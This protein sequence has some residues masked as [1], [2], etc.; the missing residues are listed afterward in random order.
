MAVRW[1]SARW[2]LWSQPVDHYHVHFQG[3]LYRATITWHKTE[4]CDHHGHVTVSWHKKKHYELVGGRTAYRRNPEHQKKVVTPEEEQ[5]RE[6]RRRECGRSRPY[7]RGPGRWFKKQTTRVNRRHAKHC[8]I[9]GRSE[10]I[11]RFYGKRY[12]GYWD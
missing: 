3:L 1:K 11:V 5:R 7:L 4:E 12:M 10:D 2:R 8:L 9:N 6:W